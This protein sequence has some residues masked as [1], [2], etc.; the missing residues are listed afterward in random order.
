MTFFQWVCIDALSLDINILPSSK[1]CID[2]FP[3]PVEMGL[4][5]ANVTPELLDKISCN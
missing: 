3:W 5:M 2:A 4:R 1:K